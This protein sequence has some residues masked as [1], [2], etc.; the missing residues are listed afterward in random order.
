VAIPS[1]DVRKGPEVIYAPPAGAQRFATANYRGGA[2]ALRRDYF[3]EAGAYDA[4]LYRQGE[5]RDLALRLMRR[6]RLFVMADIPP[7]HHHESVRRVKSATFYYNARNAMLFCWWRAPFVLIPSYL[8]IR[9]FNLLREGF[10]HGFP[11]AALR[12]LL[13]GHAYAWWSIRSRDPAR[14]ALFQ[15][16]EWLRRH[17]P[18]PLDEVRSRLIPKVACD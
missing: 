11:L 14:Y 12:G 6:G 10:Q 18:K 9:S 8:C 4:R 3:Q 5:E 15:T 2:V 7:L 13:A 17:G 16:F 1:I